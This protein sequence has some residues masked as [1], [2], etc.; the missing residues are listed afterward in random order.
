VERAGLLR[1]GAQPASLR[2]VIVADHA[3]QFPRDPAVIATLPGIGRSTANAIATFCFGAREPILDGNVKRVLCRVFGIEGY[4]GSAAVEKRLW[5]DASALL[6]QDDVP[7]YIQAQMDLGATLCTRS[8]PRCSACPVADLCI[9]HRAGRTQALPTPKAKKAIPERKV[10]LLVL[11]AG[12]RILL[13]QRPPTGIWGGLLSLPELPE[14]SD[15][16]TYCASR[17]GVKIGAVSPAPTFLHVFT[18][19]RLRIQPLLCAAEPQPLATEPNLRWLDP[20]E[21]AHAALPAPVKKLL[22]AIP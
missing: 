1:A 9:A 21:R 2:T 20:A 4:P 19:F 17:L 14:G 16:A 15:A 10:T 11:I 6:P 22:S 18:H 12:N 3:G 5:Q 8:R 7:I 13:E